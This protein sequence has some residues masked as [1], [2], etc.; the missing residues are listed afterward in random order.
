MIL[1]PSPSTYPQHVLTRWCHQPCPALYEDDHPPLTRSPLGSRSQN[2]HQMS[3]PEIKTA[4]LYLML[5]LLLT[6]PYSCLTLL[7]PSAGV[8][9]ANLMVALVRDPQQVMMKGATSLLSLTYFISVAFISVP[10]C[11]LSGWT[12]RLLGHGGI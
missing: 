12:V 10:G 5:L 11:S 6:S 4:V 1:K 7:F 2:V 3:E 9:L 8:W